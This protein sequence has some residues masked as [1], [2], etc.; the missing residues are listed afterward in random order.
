[1][2]EIKTQYDLW[3]VVQIRELGITGTIDAIMIGGETEYRVTYWFNGE[4][5]SVFLYG[6]E[7]RRPYGKDKS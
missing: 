5:F 2:M 3:E 6:Y 7:I 4:R 1:M